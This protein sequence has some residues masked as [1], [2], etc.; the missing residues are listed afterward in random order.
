[1]VTITGPARR[2]RTAHAETLP[3][4]EAQRQ[5]PPPRCT[6]GFT[7]HSTSGQHRI[8]TCDLYGVKKSA[9]THFRAVEMTVSVENTGTLAARQQNHHYPRF[10]SEKRAPLLKSGEAGKRC[11]SVANSGGGAGQ[12][13]EWWPQD[14]T[15]G[16]PPRADRLLLAILLGRSP[17]P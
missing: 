7:N 16:L 1:M 11:P 13:V 8:R 2:G 3:D 12:G 5:V 15:G 9:D 17:L 14:S 10:H 6:L 4:Q